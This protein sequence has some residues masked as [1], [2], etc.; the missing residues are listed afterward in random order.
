LNPQHLKKNQ[1]SKQTKVKTQAFNEGYDICSTRPDQ[2]LGIQ[3][4]LSGFSLLIGQTG[5]MTIRQGME[6]GKQD[7]GKN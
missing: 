2:T 7:R 3:R 4:E 5:K 6:V 1:Y